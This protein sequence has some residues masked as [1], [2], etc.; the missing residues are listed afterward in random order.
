M[1]SLVTSIPVSNS[2]SLFH[3]IFLTDFFSLFQ[4]PCG[5]AEN[6][7]EV[8]SFQLEREI[9]M[10]SLVTSIPVSNSLSLSHYI[11]LTDWFFSLSHIPCVRAENNHEVKSFQLER[12]IFLNSLVTHIPVGARYCT[13]LSLG[14]H[15]G[16]YIM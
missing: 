6:D 2:L 16:V 10:N 14:F 5:R 8:K 4:I 12:E 15:P 9:F 11:Y 13:C 1:N 3:Y 7:R